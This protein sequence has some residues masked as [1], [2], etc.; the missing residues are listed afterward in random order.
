[1]ITLVYVFILS[2]LMALPEELM[3]TP[4]ILGE[5]LRVQQERS[6]GWG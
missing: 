4:E 6:L 2:L 3:K 5:I 1:M